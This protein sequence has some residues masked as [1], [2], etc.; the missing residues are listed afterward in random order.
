MQ[1][2]VQTNNF[3]T[4][5]NIFFWVTKIDYYN[6]LKLVIICPVCFY[7][8]NYYTK[9]DNGAII[10][11]DK[12]YDLGRYSFLVDVYNLFFLYVGN[13]YLLSL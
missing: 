3:L 6:I 10:I 4:L 5:L 2:L 7:K 1:S 8:L 9:K 11:K 13:L 12:N